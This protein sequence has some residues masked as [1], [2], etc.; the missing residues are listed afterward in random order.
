MWKIIF[1]LKVGKNE[2]AEFILQFDSFSQTHFKA[3]DKAELFSKIIFSKQRSM[4]ALRKIKEN[5]LDKKK[6]KETIEI[7]KSDVRGIYK[8]I[9]RR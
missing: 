1:F 2:E 5:F 3:E 7:E 9:Q 8:I 6:E 4:E